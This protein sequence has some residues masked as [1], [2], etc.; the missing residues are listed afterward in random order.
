MMT[1][2]LL[3]LLSACASEPAFIPLRPDVSQQL[4]SSNGVI[5][6]SQKELVAEVEKSN[7][8]TYTGGGLQDFK[9]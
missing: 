3:C 9:H 4:T 8:A 7:V 6:I 2:V 5:V 1:G